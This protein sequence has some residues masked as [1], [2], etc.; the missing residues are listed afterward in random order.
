MRPERPGGGMADT[1]VSKT[2]EG[3]LVWVRLPPRAPRSRD[4]SI[5]PTFRYAAQGSA[6]SE[7]VPVRHARRVHQACFHLCPHS[8]SAACQR[9]PQT[10]AAAAVRLDRTGLDRDG[11]SV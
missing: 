6:H 3:N 10:P 1:E 4:K 5:V 2:S 11:A 7:L 8:V 9:Q